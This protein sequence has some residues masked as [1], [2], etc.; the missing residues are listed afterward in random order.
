M[1]IFVAKDLC[2]ELDQ[3]SRANAMAITTAG[4]ACSSQ[5]LLL[6]VKTPRACRAEH[7]ALEKNVRGRSR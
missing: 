3:R 5:S 1:S 7:L 4:S 6:E 2:D